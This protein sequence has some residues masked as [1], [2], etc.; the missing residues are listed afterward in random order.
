M[1]IDLTLSIDNDTPVLPGSIQPK[2]TQLT[3]ID[4]NGYNE[5]K[6]MFYKHDRVA[7]HVCSRGSV[8]SVLATGIFVTAGHRHCQGKD[9]G[10]S[11]NNGP[12]L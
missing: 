9:A 11:G 12:I 2:I 6:I 3:T 5:K 7:S 10:Y 8:G 4:T 1:Y